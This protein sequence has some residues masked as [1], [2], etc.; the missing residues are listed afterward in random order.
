MPILLPI[1]L[2]CRPLLKMIVEF[3]ILAIITDALSVIS[4][5]SVIHMKMDIFAFNYRDHKC[6]E[7]PPA[8]FRLQMIL[9]VIK[10]PVSVIPWLWSLL[11][12][13]FEKSS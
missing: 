2:T 12:Y 3:M 1:N 5:P 6:M 4:F 9:S 8:I 11:N 7:L 10:C 13:E